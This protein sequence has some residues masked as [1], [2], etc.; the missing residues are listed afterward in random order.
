QFFPGET[1]PV[2]VVSNALTPIGTTAPINPRLNLRQLSARR[3][4]GIAITGNESG[5][6]VIDGNSIGLDINGNQSVNA[7]QARANAANGIYIEYDATLPGNRTAGNT[8]G[9]TVAGAQNVIS[10]NDN[11][12]ILLV[13]Q[14]GTAPPDQIVGNLIGTDKNGTIVFDAAGLPLGN[15]LDGIRIQGLAASISG[16][17]ISG[18]G[19]SGIDVQRAV[20]AAGG[21]ITDL[22]GTTIVG[23]KI[24]TDASGTIATEVR[25]VGGS[26]TLLFPLGNTLDGILLDNVNGVTIGGTTP[27]VISGN[28]GRGIEIRGN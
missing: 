15:V 26:Q 19:L 11:N 1:S 5:G 3:S 4:N 21:V 17:V 22:T 27:N 25:P 6:N 23:N 28:L 7:N 20:N 12:G 8:I 16:N 13:G 14:L 10:G 18:N 2:L 9:S 24:G